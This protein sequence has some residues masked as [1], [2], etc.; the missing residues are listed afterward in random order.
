MRIHF[1][2]IGGAIM[3]NLAICLHKKGLTISGS[4]DIIFD[5][6]KSNLEKHGLLPD[7][8]GF[9]EE[10]I[11]THLDAIIL[12][13]HAKTDNPELN[14]ALELGI[15]VYSFPEFIFQQSKEKTRVVVAGSHGKT[16]TTAMIMHVL[17]AQN[18][19]FDY[20]VGANLDGF[21]DNVKISDAP[22]II[23]EGDEY[24][25]S[26]IEMKSKFHF[27]HPHITMITGIAWD[28]VNV[29]PTWESYTGTFKEY[30]ENIT[31]EGELIYFKGDETLTEL[32][33]FAPCKTNGYHTP[34]YEIR[35][36]I[37]YLIHEGGE[38]PLEIFGEH[39]LQNLEGARMVCNALGIDNND[40]YQ[41][42]ASFK[43]AARRLEKIKTPQG[44]SA[45]KDFAHSPSKLEAT[46]KAVKQQFADKKLIACMELHTYSSTD[47]KFLSEFKNSMLPADIAIIYMSDK[48]FEIK[49]KLKIEDNVIHRHFNQDSIIVIRTPEA[50]EAELKKH[51]A[52]EF[53]FL[54]M[55]SGNFDG[56]DM[57][58]FF[59]G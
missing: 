21:E 57:Q 48:A 22:L 43:G 55:T 23:L 30:I 24:L 5:P 59:A 26:P 31:P 34:S 4:D 51:P 49:N 13:M 16:S 20:L 50:L 32:A 53:V 9:F 35:N 17:K 2:A 19:D 3:H 6:A 47:P 25:S 1:V 28:H 18:L 27:Y 36:G 42:I 37:T 11:G 58:G 12:G 52:N 46:I 14:K 33:A 8:I 10:N 38:T 54:M 7:K 41:A 45:F 56:F 40:F 29:F 15:P 39:N 44:I